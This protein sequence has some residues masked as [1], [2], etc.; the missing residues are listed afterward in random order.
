VSIA[1]VA[2]RHYTLPDTPYNLWVRDELADHLQLPH[3]GTRVEIIGAE[4]VVSPGPT[5]GHNGI[6][7]DVTDGLAAAR[8]TDPAFPWRCIQTTDL[9]LVEIQDGYIPDLIVLETK[10]LVEARRAEAR[11][12]LPWQAHLVI[13]VTSRG[14]AADDRQPTLRR[15]SPT[16]WNGY[17]RVGIPYYLL[18][19][20][21]PKHAQAIL[22]SSPDQSSGAYGHLRSW[23]FGEVIRLPEPFG[24][25]ISTELWE[26][27][28]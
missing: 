24:F 5:V 9:N 23:E 21:G 19:D 28:P 6:V 4:I 12:L 13:E 10:I 2:H 17:A 11:H 25:E 14:N 3:D 16:K 15:A 7:Q 20:R 27:W 1:A 18:V 26:P 22:Y 8:G